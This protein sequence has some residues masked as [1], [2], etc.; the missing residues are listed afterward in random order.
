[1]NSRN[2]YCAGRDDILPTSSNELPALHVSE[3]LVSPTIDERRAGLPRL[4]F[5]T[6]YELPASVQTKYIKSLTMT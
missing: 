5:L 4:N 2:N 1:M 3:E 6:A